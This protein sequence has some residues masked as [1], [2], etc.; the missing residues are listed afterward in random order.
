MWTVW[1]VADRFAHMPARA[2]EPART[3]AVRACRPD[4]RLSLRVSPPMWIPHLR[5]DCPDCLRL[6]RAD[7]IAAHAQHR[8]RTRRR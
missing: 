4:R 6:A 7:E 3:K 5:S 2:A 8:E 1:S